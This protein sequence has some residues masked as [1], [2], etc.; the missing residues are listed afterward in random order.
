MMEWREIKTNPNYEINELGQ[1]RNKKTQYILKPFE[2]KQGHACVKLNGQ[3]KSIMYMMSQAFGDPKR[4]IKSVY[5]KNGDKMDCRLANLE[6]IYKQ[7]EWLPPFVLDL[8]FTNQGIYR[9][10]SVRK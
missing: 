2:S 3:S 4:E 9:K 5:Q 7:E 6:I 10:F 8:V 1:V